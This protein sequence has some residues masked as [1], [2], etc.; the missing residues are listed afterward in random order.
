MHVADSGFATA[1]CAY[2]LTVTAGIVTM[3]GVADVVFEGDREAECAPGTTP[4]GQSSRSCLPSRPV[5]GYGGNGIRD[6]EAPGYVVVMDIVNTEQAEHWASLASTWVEIEDHLER[7]AREPGHRAMDLLNVQ[8]GQ[9]VLDL[10]CGTGP[11]TVELARRV[12]VDGS[13]LGVDIAAEML[14]R[15]RQRAAH[16]GVSNVSFVH[17]DVQCHPLGTDAY[18]RAFSR[19]G[20]MFYADPVAAFANM[21][22]AL[23]PG[24][25]LGFVCW[26]DVMANE[27]MLV[28]GMAVMSVTG[29]PL[30]MPEPGQPGPFSLSDVGGVKELLHSAGFTKVEVIPY[31]DEISVPDSE[32]VD[33][34]DVALRVGAAREALKDVDE[35]TKAQAL[36]SVVLAL[37]EKVTD[38]ELRL[39]RGIL[40][41]TARI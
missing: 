1:S 5:D 13:V 26:Q 37:R 21:G 22:K 18:D 16:E 7:T 35:D 36:E 11:T 12:G 24:G 39:T 3:P 10:G 41:V 38:G 20:V 33:Y 6:S 28:P 32:L 9:R 23:K 27:W 30:P 8:P 31:N 19:F 4:G 29:A 2:A 17:A 40:A 15:A 25:T 34:A 14:V